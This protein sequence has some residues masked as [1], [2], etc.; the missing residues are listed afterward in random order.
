MK[1]TLKRLFSLLMVLVMLGSMLPAVYAESTPTEEP[2]DDAIVLTDEDYAIVNDVFAQIDAMEDAPAKKS[3]SRTQITDAAAQIVMASEN[4]VEGSLERNGNSFT[5]WTDEGI[6]CVYSPR[7]REI[8]DNMVAPEDPVAD[9]AYNEPVATKG[10]WPS[11]NQVYLVAPYYGHDDS[12]TN[13]YKNEA[14]AIASAVGDTSGY[15]LYS[16]TGATLD[17]VAEAM[18]NGAVVIFDS[19][20]MT[21]YENPNDEYDLVTGATSSY[22]CLTSTTGLTDEDYDDGALYYSDGIC[23]NGATIANHMTKQSPAGILWMAICLGMATDTFAV[24]MREMGVEVVYGYSQSVTFDGDYLWEEIFWDN[25]CAGTDVA[26]A[27]ADMKSKCGEW[28]YCTKMYNY[29]GWTADSYGPITSIDE[30]REYYYAFPIV[31]SDEDT[32]PGQRS[33]SSNYGADSLQTVKSTY[34]LFSQYAVSV[35]VN[36]SDYGSATASGNTITAVPAT[37]YFAES[38]EVISGTAA[39]TQNGNTFSVA[40]ESDCTVQIN[41]APKTAV[42]VN[43]SGANVSGQTGYAGDSMSLPTAEAP[44]GYKF[45]GWMT[46][47]LSGET[48]EKPSYYT[49]SFIPTG[50]TTL[51]A[52]YSYVDSASGGGSGDYVKVTES[53]DDWSGEYLIVYEAG[54]RV[55]DGSL[56]TLEAVSNYQ[57]VTISDNTISADDADAYKFIIASMDGGYSIQSASGEYISGISGSNKLVEGT[58][59][60]ANTISIDAS[61]NADI[62]SNTSHLRYNATSGQDRFRYYKSTSYSNQKPI[63]LYVKDGSA[64]TTY[65]TTTLCEHTNTSEVAAVAA[66]CTEAG[67]TAGTQCVDC[68]SYVTGHEVV[69]ALGH[70]WNDWTQTTAPGC[71]TPGQQTRTCSACGEAET[72]SVA[73]TGHSYDAGVITTAP[74]CTANG[75]KTF[76]CSAC[77]ATQTEDIPVIDHNYE[78]GI[79]T[80]CGAAEPVGPVLPK[81]GDQVVIY[82]PAYNKALSSTYTSFYN[83]GVDVSVA[84]GVVTG[85]GDTEIWTV[86]KNS[87][88]TYSFAYG[89]QNIGLADQYASMSLGGINDDWNLISLGNGLYNIQNDAR[90]NYM[91][92]YAEKNNWS[93]YN[94]TFA[95]TDDQFQLSFYIVSEAEDPEESLPE[96][97]EPAPGAYVK[98]TSAD[99]FVSGQYVMVVSTGYAPGVVSGTWLTAVTPTISGDVVTDAAGGIW[100]LTVEGSSVTITDSNGV[101]IAP[102]GGNNNGLA[103]SQYA[104]AWSFADGTF[105][106]AGTGSDT[107]KLASNTADANN[108]N[109]FRAYKNTT[110]TDSS[111]YP[112]EF[113]LYKLVEETVC[114]H[115]NTTTTTVGATSNTLGSITVTCNDCGETI[116]TQSI[117]Y[118][119]GAVESWSMTLG[120]DLSVNFRIFAHETIR[121]NAQIAVTIA[122]EAYDI[123]NIAVGEDGYYAVTIKIAAAQMADTINIQITNSN[124]QNAGVS[125]DYTV[126]QYADYI[127]TDPEGKFTDKDKALVQAMLNYGGAAQ[128]YFGY[129][130]E[131]LVSTEFGTETPETNDEMVVTDTSSDINFYGASLIFRER[132]AVRFYFTGNV[133]GKLFTV[134]GKDVE[135]TKKDD[136]YYVEIGDIVPYQLGQQYTVTADGISVT[137]GPLN[138]IVRMFEKG[139]TKTKNLMQAL[140]NYYLVALDYVTAE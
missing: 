29:A 31:V 30:A 40:A 104:W 139:D 56:A 86:I 133:E 81:N 36:N 101:S 128:T 51:Y 107:V 110:V 4:Y 82:A 92:W 72:Q 111:K 129:N 125:K 6:R 137:Y 124:G 127:L 116:S 24:P 121:E 69:A 44:E 25:M 53:R 95:A 55:F 134:Q 68:G 39:V 13:Q 54:S 15:T 106:F 76:T 98:V 91:Q 7:M 83:Q 64:G 135:A 87:D 32:H 47:P 8:Q 59:A 46:A 61:G 113:T 23:I 17:K 131:N 77:G 105:T 16:G 42:T 108:K 120:G 102:K 20:G 45:L 58:S 140:Y 132:I 96:E 114:E 26:T 5:W 118:L 136:L 3:A 37:G 71:E 93:S 119:A 73:A 1:T 88:G 41:F 18:S 62:V 89:G 43:F 34:T 33:G 115:L 75:V 48:T 85:Y 52:L 74:T 122:G 27:I 63:A 38:A 97:S 10:G 130:T 79:C 99:Q 112:S 94:S 22:L 11:G 78:D 100:T 117:P 50:N 9:G 57:N 103:T 138:Y 49:D 126:K 67:Y 2:V 66:T 70:D 60:S 84:N 90:G 109:K 65:Y 28:D 35:Q 21:D 80:G 14:T 19:H 123:G 12:F